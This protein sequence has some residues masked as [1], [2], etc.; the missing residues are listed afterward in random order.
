MMI[1]FVITAAFF[2]P[3]KLMLPITTWD[4]DM[5]ENLKRSLGFSDPMHV[6]LGRFMWDGVRLDFGQSLWQHAPSME[7]VIERLPATSLLAFTAV[8]LSFLIGVPMGTI[9]ALRPRSKLDRA[10]TILSLTGVSVADFWLGLMLILIVAVQFRLLQTSG[11]GD[12]QNLILPVIT[13]A[14]RPIGRMAQITRSAM[15][16]EM[17]RPYVVTARAKGLHESVVIFYHALKNAG[18]AIVTLGGYEIGR[19]FAGYAVVVETVFGWPGIGMLAV[20]ALEKHDL[21]LV[22]AA[23]FAA[24]SVT[25]FM[26]IFVDIIYAYLDPRIRF[27]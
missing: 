26:N 11:Y 21:P 1:V 23:V 8:A 7:L 14:A 6:R 27:S 19:I 3:A 10:S 12:L 25:I 20:Q 24:A 4:P 13:L 18:I 15:I 2:D 22:Q 9:A 5:Y 17:S 16:D